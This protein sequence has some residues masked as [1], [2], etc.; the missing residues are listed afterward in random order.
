MASSERIPGEITVNTDFD[1]I[2]TG[3]GL[4]GEAAVSRPLARGGEPR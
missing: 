4:G 2:V 3:A 1:V